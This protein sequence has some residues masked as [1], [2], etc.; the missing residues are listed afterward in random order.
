M[1][2]AGECG[3]NGRHQT[4]VVAPAVPANVIDRHVLAVDLSTLKIQ[5]W[6]PHALYEEAY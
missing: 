1:E 5:R 6:L 3:V 2:C 4:M